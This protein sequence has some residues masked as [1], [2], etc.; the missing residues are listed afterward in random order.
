L[1]SACG[2]QRPTTGELQENTHRVQTAYQGPKLR[3]AVGQFGDMEAT[4]Q[5]LEDTGWRGIAPLIAEQ[6]VTGLTQTGRVA[7]LERSQLDKLVTNLTLEK[8][9]ETARFF[10]QGTTAEIGKFLGAQVV[11]VGAITE[12]EPNVSGSDS[13]FSLASLV[14]L[15]Y[16]HDKAVVGIDVRL[17]DQATGRVMYAAHARGEVLAQKFSGGATYKDVKVGTTAWSRTPLG[18]ATRQAADDA[19]RQLI[20]A[21]QKIPFEA[22]VLDVRADKRL[23]IGA[24]HDAALKEGDRFQIVHRG[25]AITDADGKV[26]GWDEIKGGWCELQ[27]VQEKMSVATMLDGEMPKK[28][29]VVRLPLE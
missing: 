5:L 20:D 15:K 13:G 21:V 22:P 9:S 26:V 10:D 29:D 19:I 18:E 24:G 11:F 23:F 3:I 17:V 28:G 6:V 14:G 7:V 1:L 12:F 4:K 2:G 27:T 16:H 25:D 8:E